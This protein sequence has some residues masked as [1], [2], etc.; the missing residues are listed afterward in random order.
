MLFFSNTDNDDSSSAVVGETAAMDIPQIMSLLEQTFPTNDED[1]NN[2]DKQTKKWRKTRN[3]LY[4]YRASLSAAQNKSKHISEEKGQTTTTRPKQRRRRRGS[5]NREPLTLTTIHQILSFLQSTF[6]NHPTVQA[7]IIQQSPRILGQYHSIESRLIPTVEFLKGLYGGIRMLDSSGSKEGGGMFV[8]AISRNTNLLLVRGVGYAGGKRNIDSGSGS[9]RSSS[10]SRNNEG[11]GEDYCSIDTSSSCEVETYLESELGISSSGIDKLKRNHPKLFQLS[12]NE[13]V[14][15]VVQYL[16]S[17]LGYDTNSGGGTR[18][19]QPSQKSKLTKQVAKIVTKHPMLLQLDVTA[20]LGPTA[21]FL[22]DSCDLNEKELA[23]VIA[24]TPGLLGLSVEG[25]LKPTIQFLID[26]LVS[27]IGRIAQQTSTTGGDEDATATTVLLR[28][29][30]LKHPQI[31][32]LSLKNLSTKREYFDAI[33]HDKSR[34]NG[35]KESEKKKYSLAA[36]ILVSA[37]STYSLSL[38]ENIIPK[39]EHLASLWGNNVTSSS[40]CSTNEHADGGDTTTIA[41]NLREYPQILTL[42]KEG[43]IIPTLSFYNITGYIELDGDGIPTQ[44]T[45]IQQQPK[46]TIRSR[47]IATSLYNRL[48]P[49][50]HFLLEVQEKQQKLEEQLL[51][52][53]VHTNSQKEDRTPKYIIPTS[54]TDVS[55]DTVVVLPPLHLLAGASDDTFCRQM[56]LSLT[57]YLVFK[58]EAVPRLK[59]SSQ[60]DR[61]LKTGRPIDLATNQ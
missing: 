1:N 24:A 17:L 57:D 51:E 27:G 25:N 22:R 8:E 48:L 26:V 61:W 11:G 12:L 54:K 23:S 5:S 37:P 49:R 4:Q 31:L 18:S 58:E 44:Q 15:P 30:I 52:S 29:C 40:S 32:A 33:D 42:S 2:S 50:W 19:P 39:I 14:E 7:Q 55:T 20:N 35:G 9:Q 60:F 46:Y 59:F 21:C 28:K 43:N 34:S 16:Y 6:P 41:D 38:L 56:K 45:S 10:S 3:Y 47:Y 13:K 53:L 36:R